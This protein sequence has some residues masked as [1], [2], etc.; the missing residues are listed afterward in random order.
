MAL[1]AQLPRSMPSALAEEGPVGRFGAPAP[2]SPE[3]VRE[4]A[5]A[6]AAAQYEAVPETLPPS[7]ASLDYD[8]YRDIRFRPDEALFGDGES[9]YT[10]QLFHIGFGYREPTS[11]NLV[12]E[13]QARH[14]FFDP[15]MFSYG[16]TIP[17]PPTETADLGF[18]GFRIHGHINTPEHADEFAVFQGASY[19]R[20]VARDQIY[21]LSARGLAIGTADAAGEEF[22]TFREFW[23]EEPRPGDDRIVVHA[24]LDSPSA[25]GAYR[26]VIRPGVMTAMEVESELFPRIELTTVGMAPL[27]SM[28]YFAPHDRRGIDDFR[29]AVHDSEGL[30]VWNGAGEWIWRPLLNP[31]T[32]QISMFVD[33]RP[34]GFGLMQR[35]RGLESYQ[36]LEAEYHRRPSLWVEPVGD[37]GRGSVVLVEIPTSSEVHDNI[38][39]FWRPETPLL[40]G[41]PFRFSYRLHWGDGPPVNAGVG[42]VARAMAGLAEVGRPQNE[43]DKRIFV[44]DFVGNGL[45]AEGGEPIEVDASATAGL[46]APPVIEAKPEL[47]GVRVAMQFDPEGAPVAELRCL[48]MRGGS[49]I[50]ETWL[51]RWLA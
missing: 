21:G 42:R 15:A 33:E 13:G 34:K 24:L 51:H 3:M 1:A 45:F 25:A 40:P 27:T 50:S 22:P 23:I 46:L 36:D 49:P 6:L 4:R 20:A 2:F 30:L 28:F 19:F 10:L 9:P 8:Q 5:L 44:V 29:P 14:V 47:G 41:K 48:L 16:P 39:S 26:F 12:S 38:V 7:L 11:I 32:L 43:R 35:T 18:S 31:R 17:E 37:W